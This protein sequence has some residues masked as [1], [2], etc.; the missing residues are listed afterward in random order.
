MSGGKT[1]RKSIV[2]QGIK[3]YRLLHQDDKHEKRSFIKNLE[4]IML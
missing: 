4:L 1:K 2:Y 3:E